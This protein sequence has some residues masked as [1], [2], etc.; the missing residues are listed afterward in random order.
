MRGWEEGAFKVPGAQGTGGGA[1]A[2]GDTF[3]APVV[4]GTDGRAGRVAAE[5]FEVP[6]EGEAETGD[7]PG[8]SKVS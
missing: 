5:A 7:V 1:G 6:N 2:I 3:T 4:K 8:V